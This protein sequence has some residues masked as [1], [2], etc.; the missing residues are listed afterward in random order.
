MKAL[1]FLLAILL[2]LPCAAL[3]LTLYSHAAALGLGHGPWLERP[4]L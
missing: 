3:T 1:K 4:V 2:W